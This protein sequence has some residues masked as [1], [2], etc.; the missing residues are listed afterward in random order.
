MTRKDKNKDIVNVTQKTTADESNLIAFDELDRCFDNFFAQRTP[1]PFGWNFP[2]CSD[3]N[4]TFNHTNLDIIDHEIDIQSAL[5]TNVDNGQTKALFK[6][7]ILDLTLL[8]F[9]KNNR[10]SIEI[11]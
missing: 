3:R 9:E 7:D 4:I 11:K 6:N 2:V 8:K 1:F 5:S 10:K